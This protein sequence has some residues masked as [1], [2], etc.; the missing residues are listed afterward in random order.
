MSKIPILSGNL[1]GII[2]NKI[3]AVDR[4]NNSLSIDRSEQININKMVDTN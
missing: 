2:F 3:Y 4:K 1:K